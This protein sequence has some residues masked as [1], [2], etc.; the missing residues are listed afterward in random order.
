MEGG[1]G[2]SRRVVHEEG[3]RMGLKAAKWKRLPLLR[4]SGETCFR[5]IRFYYFR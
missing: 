2:I 5:G 3:P 1:N 4:V